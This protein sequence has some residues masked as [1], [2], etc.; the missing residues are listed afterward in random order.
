MILEILD[1][2]DGEQDMSEL[3]AIEASAYTHDTKEG[4][5][6]ATFTRDSASRHQMPPRTHSVCK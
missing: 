3:G 4:D 6:A 2:I 5:D 1:D